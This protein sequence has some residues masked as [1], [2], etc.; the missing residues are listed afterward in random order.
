MRGIGLTA[1]GLIGGFQDQV[2]AVSAQL[3]AQR[4]ESI[5][6]ARESAVIEAVVILFMLG[7]IGLWVSR[8]VGHG[9]SAVAA[10]ATALAA[11]ERD[12]RAPAR[13]GGELGQLG[14]AFND[15]V[16]QISVQER[17][18]EEL[19][20]IAVALTSATTEEEVCE[21]VVSRLAETFGYQYV[22]IYLIR[23]DDP[24]N[25]RLITQRGYQRVI[26]PVPVPNTVTGRSVC[27]RRPMLIADS[28]TE[29]TFLAAESQIV[30]EAVAP[31]LTPNRVLGTLVLEEETVGKLTEDDLNLITTLAHNLS[32]ALENVR[33]NREAADRIASLARANRDL[34]AMTEAGTRLAATLELDAVYTLVAEEIARIVDAPSLFITA[35]EEGADD[36]QM[37]VAMDHGTRLDLPS[38]P[39]S[40][41]LSGWTVTHG[42]P[43]YLETEEAVRQFMAESGVEP[44]SI[45]PVSIFSVPL[46]AGTRIVGAVSIGSPDAHAYTEQERIVVQTIAAQAAIAINNALLYEQVQQQ[47][48]E[49]H[50]LNDELARANTLKSEFLATMSHELRTPLN[51]II[52]FSELL[53]DDLVSD[54]EEVEDCLTDILNSGRHLLNLINDV[55][56]ISKIEAGRMELNRTTF[57]LREEIAEVMRSVNP[58]VAARTHTLRIQ[59]SVSQE[60]GVVRG[61]D[62]HDLRLTAHDS[63]NVRLLVSA[64]RQRVRQ[65]IL[66]LVSNAI[67]FTPDGGTITLACGQEVVSGDDSHDARP[68]YARISVTDTGIGIREEDV[69]KLFEKFRQLD[70]SHNRKYEG[71][72]L[73]LAL[74]KQLVELHG[75]TV[76]VTSTFGAGTTFSF[77]LPLTTDSPAN[78]IAQ[79]A[80]DTELTPTH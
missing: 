36:I 30:S 34:A 27:E 78:G 37:R 70:A 9:V 18:L 74:T 57:D 79:P 42:V 25:L 48:M 22:S 28:R 58:L 55:L 51:A 43:L 23:P 40:T 5:Q 47:V 32:V 14:H 12:V 21:L 44:L 16:T 24:D 29:S 3:R 52:G 66:N 63:G 45:A 10:A 65:I 20:K 71:T 19:R 41:S 72:G 39:V 38:L 17:Q 64:D 15:M 75:G 54:P 4:A 49:M 11:G 13:G 1:S 8:V 56:D 61:D 73:G 59:E 6:I 50:R 60:S 69:P 77:T 76:T 31:I 67:K 80:H 2:R 26:D 35:W 53:V 7:A 33:L 62:S 46:I 68:A